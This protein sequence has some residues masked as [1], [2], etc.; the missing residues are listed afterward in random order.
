MR[1]Y[2]LYLLAVA[3]VLTGCV[4]EPLMSKVYDPSL[5]IAQNSDGETSISWESETDY[6]YTIYYMDPPNGEWAKLR[7]ATLIQGTG[8]TLTT[9]D[10]VDPA[11]P[12]RRYRLEFKRQDY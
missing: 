8:Q 7:G 12:M 10:R 5:M 9:M 3:L 2:R 1:L 6:I 11:G 4:S